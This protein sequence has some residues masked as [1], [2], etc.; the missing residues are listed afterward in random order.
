M[1]RQSREIDCLIRGNDRLFREAGQSHAGLGRVSAFDIV[2]NVNQ[3]TEEAALDHAKDQL[4]IYA[5]T[6]RDSASQ[7]DA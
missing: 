2:L 3:N 4:Y 6:V 1:V 7:I 5:L